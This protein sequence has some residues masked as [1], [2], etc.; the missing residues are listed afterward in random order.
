VVLEHRVHVRHL[1][2]HVVEPGALVEHAEQRVMVDVLVAAIAPVEGADQM[3]LGAGVHV[4]RAEE[5]ERL[6]KPRRRL[7]H[8]RRAE[9]AVAH[10]L[11]RRR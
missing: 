2:R 11:D 4:V 9:H 6:A 1:E 10:A 3:V 5:A 8:F 7:A